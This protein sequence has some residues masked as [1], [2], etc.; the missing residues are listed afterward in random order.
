MDGLR[1]KAKEEK[2]RVQGF[3]G[4]SGKDRLKADGSPLNDGNK[5]N[6]LKADR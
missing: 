5:K 3:E 4:S 2:K 1:G 6:V